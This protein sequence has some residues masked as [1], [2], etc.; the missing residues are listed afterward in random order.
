MVVLMPP[1]T[2]QRVLRIHLLRHR[3]VQPQQDR[4]IDPALIG[5]HIRNLQVQVADP[6]QTVF[7][8]PLADLLPLVEHDEIRIPG[9]QLGRVARVVVAPPVLDVNHH[10]DSV[11]GVVPGFAA[12]PVHLHRQGG[13]EGTATRLDD[14]PVG[15]DL[16]PEGV[17]RVPELSHEIAADAAIEELL[18]ATDR[19]RRR[20]FRVDGEIAELVLEQRE[21]VVLG[22]LGDEVQDE[23][24]FTGAQ[25]AGD[26]GDRDWRHGR[27]CQ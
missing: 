6:I 4:D 1:G 12:E 22:Q 10:D 14:N 23:R 9:L 19:R 27:M 2:L 15:L 11:E 25:K 16:S 7:V 5:L 17:Q 3:A 21:S 18:H 13:R 26:Y 24:R 8:P 20:E